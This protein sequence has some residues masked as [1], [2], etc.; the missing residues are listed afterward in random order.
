LAPAGVNIAQAAIILVAEGYAT[1]ASLHEATGYPVAVAFDAGNLQPVAKALWAANPDALLVLC[2]DD[3]AGTQASTG[4]NPG[5]EKASAAARVVKGV[6]VFPQGLAQGA[7][8]FN[9]LH[10]SAGLDAVRAQVQAAI[11]VHTPPPRPQ[12]PPHSPR[13]GKTTTPLK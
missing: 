1:A 9:D 11:D 12:P 4:R 13:P 6:A 7:T 10:A 5:R 2:G 8:D 3:D